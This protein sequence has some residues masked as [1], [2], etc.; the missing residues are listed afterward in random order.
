MKD[1]QRR[2]AVFD[3]AFREDLEFRVSTNPR[4]ALKVLRLVDAVLRDPF[5]GPGKPE[6]LRH[7]LVGTWSRRI[8]KEHRLVHQVD[9]DR[10]YFLA[11]RYHY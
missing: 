5:Y 8:D 4:T 2:D 10:V 1:G 3:P 11:A 9:D 7:R 6:P